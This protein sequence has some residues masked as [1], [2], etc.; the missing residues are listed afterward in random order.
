MSKSKYYSGTQLLSMRDVNGNKPEIYLCTT[1]RTGGKTTFFNRMLVKQFIERKEKFILQ[2]RYKYEIDDVPTNFFKD[3]R[4]LFF[5]DYNMDCKKMAQGVYYELFLNG[6]A[7][8]YALSLSSSDSIKKI[9]HV[10]T[11]AC[12]ILQDEFQSENGTYLPNEINRFKSIH[13]SIARGRGKQTRYLPVYMLSNPITI[14][15][16]YYVALGITERLEKN[17][18]FLRGVGW[19]LEQGFVESA[20][21]ALKESAF[22]QAFGSDTYSEYVINAHYL[23]DDNAFIDTP[24]GSNRYLCTIKFEGVDYAIRQFDELGLLYCDTSIDA[25][26]PI[27][28]SSTSFDHNV[29]YI[30]V[31]KFNYIIDMLRNVFEIGHFR[32]KNINC[33]NAV[34]SVIKYKYM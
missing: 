32:F 24:K 10:F 5:P 11:D 4:E 15:N 1:N 2:Y 21:N 14:L 23:Y 25:S 13:N 33:K 12:K 7:C 27:K 3:I 26:Y 9:S 8:G 6:V 28:F 29:N 16:P 20:S 30:L 18:K 17:T 34:L 31:N 19:V 22:M